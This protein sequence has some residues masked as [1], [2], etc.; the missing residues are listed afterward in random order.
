MQQAQTYKRTLSGSVGAGL[1]SVFGGGGRQYYILEHKISS[2]YH[3]VGDNQEIIVDQVEIGRDPKC[4]VRFDESFKT[5]SRRHAAIEKDGDKWKLVQLSATNPTFL[6]GNPVK[7]EWYLQNGDEIQ[8]STGGPKLGFLIPAGKTTGTLGFTHRLSLF[9]KQALRPYKQAVTLLS[10]FLLLAIGG[11]GYAILHQQSIIGETQIGLTK[12]IEENKSLKK[13]VKDTEDKRV[14]DSIRVANLP[15]PVP[16]P[17]AIHNL[18]AAVKKDIYFIETRAFMQ[19]NAGTQKLATSYGT[20]FVLQ[21]G[22]FV[23]A[24]HCVETWLFDMSEE[25]VRANANATTYS[26]EYKV[27]SEVRAYNKSGLQFT[28]KSA[29][30]KINRSSDVIKQ[31]GVD[32]NN[33]PIHFQFAFPNAFKEKTIG[34]PSMLAHD[35]A[36]ARVSQSSSLN[37]DYEA[38]TSLRTGEE[39]HILGFPDG[40]GVNDGKALVEPIY[41]KMSVSRDGLDNAG[42]IMTSSGVNHGNSGGP[43]FALRGGKLVVVGIVS[44]GSSY[45]HAVPISQIK[46]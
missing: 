42:C 16:P 32:E 10:L 11:G 29:D 7:R 24:R 14:Q 36:V 2:K 44:R 6:N 34:S 38:S 39:I 43:V 19:D 35:W 20:G 17:P 13:M 3:R 8:L 30:F 9:G 40:Y 27:Y 4:Q 28:L 5:V 15:K 22:T 37:A 25:S 23:T 41:N 46:N 21:D 1:G 18:I 45:D 31:I 26:T 12:V 33:Q